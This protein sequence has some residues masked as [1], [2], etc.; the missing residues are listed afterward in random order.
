MLLVVLGELPLPLRPSNTWTLREIGGPRQLVSGEL[1]VVERPWLEALLRGTGVVTLAL[2]LFAVLPG[3]AGRR[4]PGPSPIVSGP[5][6]LARRA[7]AA[8]VGQMASPRGPLVVYL[9]AYLVLV[10]VLWFYNDRYALV[11]L[12]LVVAL[13]LGHCRQAAAPPHAWAALALFAVVA[14]VGTRDTL[15][16][17]QA[18]R[19]SWQSLVDSGVPPSDIDAGY[20]WTGWV[21]YAHPENLAGGPH[22]R[23]RAVDHVEASAPVHPREGGDR[24]LRRRPGSDLE[25]RRTWPGPDRLF[26]LK[27]RPSR[28]R[29]SRPASGETLRLTPS[30]NSRS[31]SGSAGSR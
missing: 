27:Q 30:A 29:R 16:F 19:D 25:R 10:N 8:V 14:V 9:V 28:G 20:V 5:P 24:G 15:R 13:A 1:P 26:I 18:V 11:L 4:E 22:R 3:K 12:P 21:L 17:N 23:R 6:S 7:I 2:A 31:V